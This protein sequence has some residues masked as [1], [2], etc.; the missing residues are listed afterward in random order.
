[1]N[2][3]RIP[4]N[5][6][7]FCDKKQQGLTQRQAVRYKSKGLVFKSQKQLFKNLD[8]QYAEQERPASAG[9]SCELATG[10]KGR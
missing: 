5:S 8:I 1:M 10:T 2:L 9:P 4:R 6:K 3:G 7:L